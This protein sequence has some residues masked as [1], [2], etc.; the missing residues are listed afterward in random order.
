MEGLMQRLERAV[1]RLEQM[2]STM[3]T[4]S[5]M[6][7]GDCVNGINGGKSVLKN[8]MTQMFR[9]QNSCLVCTVKKQRIH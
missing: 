3:Q 2:S 7:N 8:D 5:S 9:S 6:A 4:S 1:T